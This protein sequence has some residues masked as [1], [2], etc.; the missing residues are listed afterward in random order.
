MKGLIVGDSLLSVWLPNSWPRAENHISIIRIYRS[1]HLTTAS[2]LADIGGRAFC[3]GSS[4]NMSPLR[5][6]EIMSRRI[7]GTASKGSSALERA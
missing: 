4:F 2:R 7:T 5:H 6:A 1:E 3:P